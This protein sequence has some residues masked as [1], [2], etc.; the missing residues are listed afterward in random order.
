MD[1]LVCGKPIGSRETPMHYLYREDSG[2]KRT[3]IEGFCSMEHALKWAEAHPE[4]VSTVPRCVVCGGIIV[5]APWYA[6]LHEWNKPRHHD[7]TP[8]AGV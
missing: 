8:N 1:C 3:D 5:N 4:E 2:G 6:S 7:C